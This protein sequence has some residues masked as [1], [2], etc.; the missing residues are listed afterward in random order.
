MCESIINA[1]PYPY[2]RLR[3]D[4][5]SSARVAVLGAGGARVAGSSRRAHCQSC[6]RACLRVD[7]R[8]APVSGLV[9]Y[10]SEVYA[11]H[12]LGRRVACCT[13]CVY[14]VGGATG[15]A[16]LVSGAITARPTHPRT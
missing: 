1:L 9:S 15:V 6:S 12:G 11:R 5:K 4:E 7:S 13:S 10:F 16:G 2:L 3:H 14:A 8:V